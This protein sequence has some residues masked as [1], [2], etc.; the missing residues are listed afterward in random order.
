M[1]AY[2]PQTQDNSGAILAQGQIGA[3]QTNAE[4][5]NNLGQNIGSALSA[6]GGIYGKAAGSAKQ[7]KDKFTGMF[8]FLQSKN[9][10]SPSA[11]VAIESFVQ[12]KDFAGANA[13]IAPYLAELDFG[14]SSMLAGRSGFFDAKGNWQMALR[15]EP[16]NP[17]NKEG[18]V[19]RGG[20]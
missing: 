12:K 19:Y 17:P 10:V 2:N 4:S 8:D 5:M 1:F 9:L 6:I 18:Y 7:E 20:Q 16:V 11:Q 3:A 13:Y 14:R 15:P